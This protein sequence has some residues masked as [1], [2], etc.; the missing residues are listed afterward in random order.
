MLK[1]LT[2]N[3]ILILIFALCG[4][5]NLPASGTRLDM[6]KVGEW[7]AGTLDYKK[8]ITQ[9]RYAYCAAAEGGV[10]ILDVIAPG[11][12]SHVSLIHTPGPALDVYAAGNYLFVAAG[13]EGVQVYDVSA[14]FSPVRAGSYKPRHSGRTISRFAVSGNYMYIPGSGGFTVLDISNPAVPFKAGS[15]QHEENGHLGWELDDFTIHGKYLYSI[16]SYYLPGR[17]GASSPAGSIDARL[18]IIDISNPL[19]PVKKSQF[20]QLNDWWTEVAA[21][22][23]YAYMIDREGR[24]MVMDISDPKNPVI[25]KRFPLD[26]AA[27]HITLTSGYAYLTG[28]DFPEQKIWVVDIANPA[29][30][31]LARSYT[32]QSDEYLNHIHIGGDWSYISKGVEGLEIM[33]V[34]EPPV[35]NYT[36]KYK[37][38]AQS[39]VNQVVVKGGYAYVLDRSLGLAVLDITNPS[40]PVLLGNNNS[41]FGDSDD[42]ARK[43]WKLRVSGNLALVVSSYNGLEILDISEPASP[44]WLGSYKPAESVQD[45]D[46]DGQGRF[47]YV[48]EGRDGLQVLD[49]SDPANPV[50]R[51]RYNA[52]QFALSVRLSHGYAF[53]ADSYYGLYTLDISD[54]DNPKEVGNNNEVTISEGLHINGEYLYSLPYSYSGG[55][56]LDIFRIHN[57]TTLVWQGKYEPSYR[58]NGIAVAAPY[59]YLTAR[60]GGV[61]VLDVSDPTAPE[62]IG[63]YD[64]PGEE[65][66]IAAADGLIYLAAGKFLVLRNNGFT[67]GPALSVNR[68]EMFFA[69]GSEGS[70]ASQ[71]FLVENTGSGTLNWSVTVNQNW[72][73]ASPAAG[74][75]SGQVTVTA[76]PYGLAPGVYWGTV[77]VTG[78]FAAHSP[79]HIIVRFTVYKN[80]QSTVPFGEFATPLEGA[81]VSGSIPVTGWTLDDVGVQHVRIFR[82]AGEDESPVFVGDA[83]FV[84]GAR[85]D[86]AQAYPGYPGST[87]A[88]WGYMLLTNFLPGGGNGTFILTAVATDIEG[89]QVTLGSRTII[90]DND[91][92][93]KPFGAI[94]APTQGGAIAG[95]KYVVWGWALTPQP[96]SIPTDGSTIRVW[97]DGVNLGHPVYN[98]YR[99]DIAGLFPGYANS[100]GAIGYIYLD[101]GVYQNGVHTIQWT[102]S[103]GAG[104]TD[105]IGSR[106]FSIQN[107]SYRTTQQSYGAAEALPPDT[108][109]PVQIR[110]G[111]N[112]AAEL[113]TRYPD[114][115]GNIILTIKPLQRLEIRFPLETATLTPLPIGATFKDGTFTWQTGPGFLGPHHLRFRITGP[116]GQSKQQEIFI[117]IDPYLLTTKDTKGTKKIE[118]KRIRR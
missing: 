66:A 8:V 107:V 20:V 96:N 99:K 83:V 47:A 43:Y 27:D 110:T 63:R 48:A 62:F 77:T 17:A 97:V 108:F 1:Q 16:A 26:G 44:R 68:N 79:H 114:E 10:E 90:C 14:P 55:D 73:A 95:D 6:V 105:G 9:G 78:S 115:N 64:S 4:P 76:N 70:S 28:R 38:P 52:H 74:N 112:P 98:V 12:P 3:L 56:G 117:H 57:S 18:I 93:V 61:Q 35:M 87:R 109:T 94:D 82:Q 40:G 53:L 33:A 75:N 49:I 11:S 23:P 72:L 37:I 86:V 101:T 111:Y 21:Q 13:D 58:L 15:F 84:E 50:K 60:D 104:N 54:P 30:P 31:S 106:Y 118:D 71:S 7:G 100:Q 36:G 65:T 102:V 39:F 80:Q 88:G 81:V 42:W 103:D 2:I 92:A 29:A 91:N 19:R 85:P 34:P 45:V 22:G 69:S 25:L 46:V 116:D 89:N 67:S 113:N 59:V 32:L 5:F 41:F 51:G 24:L